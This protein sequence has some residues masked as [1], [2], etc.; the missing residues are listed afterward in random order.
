MADLLDRLAHRKAR[1]AQLTY[2]LDPNDAD[3]LAEARTSVRVARRAKERASDNAEPGAVADAQLDVDLAEA[4]AELAR[5]MDEMVTFTVHLRALDPSQ[6]EALRLDHQPTAQQV[7]TAVRIAGGD[8][9][10]RPHVNEDTYPAA[11]LADAIERVT[12]SD[13]PDAVLVDLEAE[14]VAKML[15][16]CS[17]GDRI[18]LVN[19][20]ELLAQAPSRVDDL[21]K[22]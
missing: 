12:I 4:E 15:K 17:Q 21:G 1:S 19:T 9:K 6:I 2:P 3:R 16:P 22:G 7:K 14:Q 8:P 18:E 10:A 20:A 5:L 11:L 13:D